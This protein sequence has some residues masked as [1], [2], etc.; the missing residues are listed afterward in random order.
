M[1]EHDDFILA[2]LSEEGSIDPSTLE[3]CRR[4]AAEQ[5]LSVCQVLVD[6]GVTTARTLALVRAGICEVPFVDLDHFQIDLRNSSLLARSSAQALLAFPLFACE[7]LTTVGMANPLDLRAVDQLRSLIRGDI[8]LV[9][10]EPSALRALID[11]AYS[12]SDSGEAGAGPAA[13]ADSLTTGK[14]PIVAAVNQILAD[15][16]ERGA[17]DVHLGP[18][19]QRL[20]LRL[21][22]DGTLIALQA[23]PLSAH[24][25]LVQRLKVMANLDLTQTRR[26]Q[27][28]KFRFMHAGR[29]VD[30][31]LSV[32]PTVA[33]ENIVCRLLT[34]ASGI[35]ELSDLG[36]SNDHARAMTECLDAPNG[37]LLVT[38]P[39]GSGKTTTLYAGL[40]RLNSAE[41]NIVTI[42]DPVEVR[43][44]LIRQ[45]QVSPEIGLNFASALRSILRQDPDV[46]LVGEIR[47]EETARIALQ[48]ALTG[49]L[50]LSSLHTNDALGAIPRLLDFGCPTFAV[51]SALLGIVAQ[52][53]AKRVCT[54]CPE[55]DTPAADAL[56]RF[57]IG[58]GDATGFTRGKGCPRCAGL[59]TRGRIGLYEV[60]R[61]SPVIRRAVETRDTTKIMAAAASDGFR[62]MWHDGVQKARLGLTTLSEVSRVA[63][64]MDLDVV[65]EDGPGGTG[66]G[67]DGRKGNT[68]RRTA[69]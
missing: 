25:G 28:G 58:P 34:S 56:A 63:A 19:D 47:D 57:S 10:C 13:T 39:T 36:F 9:L 38:G 30:V 51:S 18:D 12:I 65:A 6:R 41:R 17:S 44:P 23:P 1:I 48:S 54:Y 4:A 26:P 35:R 24:A 22:I 43:M 15:A 2:A 64:A 68:G 55:R 69:A 61:M 62:P 11:R 7:G 16:V 33:G 45:V 3:A 42:E 27:D 46:I 40:K 50:V 29:A 14:E 32:I 59:G 66:G 21:R 5:R 31:R 8:E 53:L 60:I 49:H 37:M 20:H 67:A 52:R